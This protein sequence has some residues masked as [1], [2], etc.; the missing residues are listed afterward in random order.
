MNVKI[1]EGALTF[2]IREVGLEALLRG[3]SLKNRARVGSMDLC[4]S[5]KPA[6]GDGLCADLKMIAGGLMLEAEAGMIVL[7]TLADMGKSREGIT[8]MQDGTSITLQVDVK[9]DNRVVRK[10]KR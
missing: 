1:E 10:E 6:D 7:K 3:E 8:V 5:I 9:N 2:K 4:I